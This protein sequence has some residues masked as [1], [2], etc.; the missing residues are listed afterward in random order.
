MQQD[1]LTAVLGSKRLP[2]GGTASVNAAGH[3][4]ALFRVEGKVY[5][6]EDE[7]PHA[8]APLSEGWLAGSAQ[9]PEVVCPL[10]LWRFRL[11]DGVGMAPRGCRV[12]AYPASER[13]GQIW[14]TLDSAPD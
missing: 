9:A 7:C 1:R 11:A 4:I 14:I 8:G 3:R 13:D 12:R 10:H 6:L 2:P 5:A